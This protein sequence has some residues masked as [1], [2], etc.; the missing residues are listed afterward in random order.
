MSNL[1]SPHWQGLVEGGGQFGSKTP[2]IGQGVH[3]QE[4]NCLGSSC[5]PNDGVYK[6]L[7]IRSPSGYATRMTP[8]RGWY[9]VSTPPLDL[10]ISLQGD[11][12]VLPV[13]VHPP[14]HPINDL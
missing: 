11:L 7:D 1:C 3:V 8:K 14:P 2:A 9:M 12:S 4:K 13:C 6:G 10:A 5:L